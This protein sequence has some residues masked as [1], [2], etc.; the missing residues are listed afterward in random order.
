MAASGLPPYEY[1]VC[2]T[3]NVSDVSPSLLDL[4]KP[5]VTPGYSTIALIQNGLNIEKPFIDAFPEN[6]VLSGVSF[7]GSH[8]VKTGEIVHDDND[9]VFIG[10]FD[11]PG[12]DREIQEKAARD[13]VKI[14]GAGGKCFPEYDANV[15]WTRWRKLLYNACLNSICAITDL[16]TG[17]IQIADGAV[18]AL[19]RPAME[20]IR[21]GARACG[22]DLPEN[23]VDFMIRKDPI[24]MYNPPSMQVDLRKV[25]LDRTPQSL[26]L[27]L[28]H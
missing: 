26:H 24:T 11:N 13:F 22:H 4:I 28:T 5:A 3:K 16:D 17:R 1:I 8:E 20:E 12:V 10:A 25:N 18:V 15:G 7:C 27:S 19:V 6:I 21:A 14:Y 9:K 23:L 2:T